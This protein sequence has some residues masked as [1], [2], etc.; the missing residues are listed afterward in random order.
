MLDSVVSDGGMDQKNKKTKTN[1][2]TMHHE[3]TKPNKTK[4]DLSESD[5]ENEGTES[6]RF[7][8]LESLEDI[9]YYLKQSK[10]LK[11]EKDKERHSTHWR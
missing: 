11:Y 1:K 8:A 4:R 9:R 2:Q 7:I 3:N 10:L 6:L 5:S